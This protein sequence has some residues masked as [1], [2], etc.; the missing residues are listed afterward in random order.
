[1]AKLSISLDELDINTR[2]LEFKRF[3]PTLEKAMA[4]VLADHGRKMDQSQKPDGSAQK[5]NSPGY[6]ARKSNPGI[7]VGARRIRGQVPTILTSE[8][9]GSRQIRRRPNAV[10]AFFAGKENREKAAALVSMGYGI[11][12]FSRKNADDITKRVNQE[13]DKILDKA[14]KV[15]K[16]RSPE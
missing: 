15:K 1:M 3:I 14:I 5:R 13:L 9:K 8:M 6:A 16:D 12:F 10:E 7:R 4:E 2:E 11:H